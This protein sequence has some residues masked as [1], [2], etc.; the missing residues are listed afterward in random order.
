MQNNLNNEEHI[1]KAMEM[2]NENGG[3]AYFIN[4]NVLRA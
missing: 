2:D 3:S 1:P 4:P